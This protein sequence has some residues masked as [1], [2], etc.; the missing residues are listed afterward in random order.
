[1]KNR[2]WIA[3]A[4]CAASAIVVTSLLLPD[5][6]AAGS[7]ETR[8]G[9]PALTASL[10][11]RV[12]TDDDGLPQNSIESL[13]ISPDG[14][15]WATTRE[16]GARFDGSGWT[17][18]T[19]PPRAG[20]NWP[21]VTLAS[22][23]GA[24]WF[25]TEGGGLHRYASGTWSSVSN[26]KIERVTIVALA[27]SPGSRPGSAIWAGS[28][29]G[30]YRIDSRSLQAAAVP[31]PAKA[32]VTALLAGST[33]LLVGTADGV[34]FRCDAGHCVRDDAASALAAGARIAGFAE[35][36]D[37]A[38]SRTTWIA[39]DRGV[40]I[41]SPGESAFELRGERV[42]AVT[43]TR[44]TSGVATAWAALDGGGIRRRIGG[45]WD[46]PFLSPPLPNGFIFTLVPYPADGPTRHLFAG[47]LNGVVR[48]DVSAWRSIDTTSGLPDA[49]VVSILETGSDAGG[50]MLLGTTGGLATTTGK[51]WQRVPSDLVANAP[52]FALMRSADGT[53][54]Y[55][56]T[57]EGLVTRRDGRWS[58]NDTEGLP[59]ASVVSLLETGDPN[60]RRLWAGTYGSGLWRRD[61]AGPWRQVEGL[62]DGRVEALAADE[63]D[64]ALRVWVATDR[65][66]AKIE[67]ESVEV[68]DR[69]EGLPA[70]VIRSLL[71]AAGPDGKRYV[72]VGTAAGLAWR[73]AANDGG[74]WELVSKATGT[75]IPGENVY[76][77][78]CESPTRFWL[79]TGRGVARVS[80]PQGKA[81]AASD[82]V[83]EI[84]TTADGLPGNE[85]NFGAS[86][87]DSEGRVWA[88]TTRG[89]AV[90]DPR[91]A[92]EDRTPKTLVITEARA[93]RRN[94]P[95]SQQ[96]A[97]S[98]D[99]NDV[100]FGFRIID[101]GRGERALYRTQMVGLEKVPGDWNRTSE[102]SFTGLAPGRYTFRVWGRD[103]AGNVSGPLETSFRIVAPP[104]RSWWATLAYIALGI[105]TLAGLHRIRVRTLSARAERLER[106][107]RSRT[108]DLERM[109]RELEAANA[110][111]ADMSVTD[112]LTG[113]K[114]RRFLVQEMDRE[115]ER[116]GR[117]MRSGDDLMFF[118]VDIDL[119]KNVNDSFGHTVGDAILRQ[120]CGTLAA[121]VRETDTI[122][123]WGGEE[124]LVVARRSSRAEAPRIADRIIET[125]RAEVFDAFDG[126]MIQMTCSLGWAVFPFVT[127]E[128][129]L[130]TW[131]E[132][133]DIADH[134]L[135]SAKA[136]GRN[137]W[138]GLGAGATLQSDAFF[139][140]LRRSVRAMTDAA[141]LEVSTSLGEPS[142]L[143]WP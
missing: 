141:E 15:L 43:V 123:R 59:R 5:A 53:T 24:A 142:Q 109:N 112:P 61:S 132:V 63:H 86:L 120:F 13:R 22:T 3:G 48:I 121:A 119:F 50:E 139:Q 34:V 65:G 76:Q 143:N 95:L 126:R 69:D 111:L 66:L 110:A 90:F 33:S 36:V 80:F 127:R 74:R 8:V 130:F 125:V 104:W 113:A 6:L 26:E 117:S 87:I 131:E 1:M 62:P 91:W 29:S 73:E 92:T 9:D 105:G 108:R 83:F 84:F 116:I 81:P 30:L 107:V 71:I 38:G 77:V 70:G 57:N 37:A 124:F 19:M 7:P 134:C 138:V 10:H 31:L 137:C 129:A 32:A 42:N 12:F 54:I 2:G 88:G 41:S 52:V 100:A 115:S 122:V 21:R 75:A 40:A 25:A 39:T 27:E 64:G 18:L 23:D 101:P 56:G 89:A 17:P 106:I 135:L 99:D 16:G 47:T 85:C 133:V 82:A 97:L 103:A 44:D 94:V 14:M 11:T 45:I 140:R 72:W 49:S 4:F 20:S 79:F 35:S 60:S 51:S 28:E 118:V 58:A 67:G 93:L 46:S 114:N 78:R 96:P 136:S 102:R 68:V 98:H 55:A 128:P